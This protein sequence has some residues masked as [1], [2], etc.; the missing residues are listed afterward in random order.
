MDIF[1]AQYSTLSSAALRDHIQ[2]AYGFE[3]VTCNLLVKNVSDVYILEHADIKYIFKVYRKSYRTLYEIK[4]E[5]EL[6]DI[7]KDKGV[8]VSY[9]I[10][11]LSGNQIQAFQAAEGLRN[12]VL[13][14]FAKGKV[15]INP[16]E[17]PYLTSG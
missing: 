6:L 4:A 2:K 1:P 11:D 3:G 17:Q 8:P 12:G 10:A 14:S 13:F 9:A 16:D 5:V 7:L 15:A